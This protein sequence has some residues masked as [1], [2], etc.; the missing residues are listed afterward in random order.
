MY[1]V[2]LMRASPSFASSTTGVT[3]GALHRVGARGRTKRPVLDA[4]LALADHRQRQVRERRQVPRSADRALRRDARVHPPFEH[5]EEH[6]D[7]LGPHAAAPEGE[8]LRA[9]EHHA[10][11]LRDAEIGPDAAGVRAHEVLLELRTSLAEM[12][13]SLSAPKPVFTP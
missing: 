7:E 1:C 3:A 5:R 4:R 2:P 11:H 10:A 6:L 8:H 12:R 13:V 9:Q